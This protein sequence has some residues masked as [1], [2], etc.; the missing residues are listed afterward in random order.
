MPASWRRNASSDSTAATALTSAAACMPPSPQPA[1][2]RYGNQ[3]MPQTEAPSRMESDA[4]TAWRSAGAACAVTGF[5]LMKGICLRRAGA[6]CHAG[7]ASPD[8]AG[9]ITAM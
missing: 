7:Q 9:G 5:V 4:L 1:S 6:C 8:G 3:A 2:T